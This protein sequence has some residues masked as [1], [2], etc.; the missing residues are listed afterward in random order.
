MSSSYNR[1]PG[2]FDRVMSGLTYLSAGMVGF[3]WLIV[4]AFRGRYPDEFLM[5]HIKQSIFFSLCYILMD[6]V[7]WFL[8]KILEYIPFINKLVRQ[9]VFIFNQPMVVGYSIMQCVI[10]GIVIYLAV[11]AM[12]GLYSYLP[13][14]SD[15]LNGYFRK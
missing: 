9:I 6:A 11:F 13:V 2:L 12:M 10:Y 4:C 5:Y 14:L 15:I 1:A 8:V 7:F 3:V